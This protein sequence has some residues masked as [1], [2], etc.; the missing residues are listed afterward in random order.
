MSY[1]IAYI[2]AL[3]LQALYENDPTGA[4]E[5]CKNF[6]TAGILHNHAGKF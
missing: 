3:N 4:V 1:M 5:R 6:M 2:Y